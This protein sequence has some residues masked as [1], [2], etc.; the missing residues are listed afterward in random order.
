M[1]YNKLGANENLGR[2]VLRKD[3]GPHGLTRALLGPTPAGLALY[4]GPRPSLLPVTG[5][6][7]LRPEPHPSSAIPL[8]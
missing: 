1:V 2:K 8:T 3:K 5:P 6:H 4:L 7:L